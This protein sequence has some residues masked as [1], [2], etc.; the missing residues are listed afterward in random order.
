MAAFTDYETH[1]ALGL[2]ALVARGEITPEEVLEA[3]VERVDARD[4]IVNA[5]TNRLY[6]LGRQ[7]IADGLPDGPLR[8]VPYLLKDLGASLAG[9]PTTRGCRFFEDVVPAEDSEHV[10]RLKRPAWS[11]SGGP[12]PASSA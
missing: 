4:G 6:D 10:K 3:A 8:G 7:A 5:V 1:D 9:C 2:A 11:S 12:T